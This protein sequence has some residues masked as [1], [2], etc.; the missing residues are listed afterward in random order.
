METRDLNTIYVIFTATPYRTGRFIR[1]VTRYRY[2]HVSIS[3]DQ[4][5]Q[6]MFSFSRYYKNTPLYAGFVQESA[7]RYRLGS[8]IS[9]IKILEVPLT[10]EQEATLLGQLAEFNAH[11]RHYIYNFSSALCV[12][13]RHRV[14]IRDSYTCVEFVTA[15]LTQAGLINRPKDSF[16]S[17]PELEKSIEGQV[18]YEGSMAELCEGASWGNDQFCEHK[19]K[20]FYMSC[21]ARNLL[22][23]A[24]RAMQ[25]VIS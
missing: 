9:D 5:L 23:L 21:A 2:N 7:C 14:C 10:P 16:C 24:Y 4:G 1:F 13:I 17:I 6:N 25:G 11:P 22:R 18:V 8:M 12:P 19:S 15:I 20:K 3:L